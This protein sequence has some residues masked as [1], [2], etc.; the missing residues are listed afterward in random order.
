MKARYLIMGFGVATF[1]ISLSCGEKDGEGRRAAEGALKATQEAE[2]AERAAREAERL[3]D[4][5]QRLASTVKKFTEMNRK[6]LMEMQKIAASASSEKGGSGEKTPEQIRTEWEELKKRLKEQEQMEEELLREAAKEQVESK[7]GEFN[8][9][10]RAQKFFFIDETSEA[11]I[12]KKAAGNKGRER[13]I[14]YKPKWAAVCEEEWTG[15][16]MS[17]EWEFDIDERETNCGK[18]PARNLK[19]PPV[20]IEQKGRCLRFIETQLALP[21]ICRLESDTAFD[22]VS[23]ISTSSEEKLGAAEMKCKLDDKY[24]FE[25][26]YMMEISKGD[27]CFSAGTISGKR[28]Y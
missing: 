24:R 1:I 25:C 4:E 14:A 26:R 22:C 12:A 16:K 19:L 9:I 27:A 13:W 10:E 20:D 6:N 3:R 18:K 15:I 2:R 7:R 28:I 23:L 17:G 5:T 11:I 8:P 21:V